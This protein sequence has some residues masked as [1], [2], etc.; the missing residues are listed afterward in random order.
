MPIDPVELTR[1]LVRCP[2]VTPAE[3]GALDTLEEA[4][5]TLGIAATRLTFGEDKPVQ[6]LFATTGGEG[7]GAKGRHLA[8]N[9]HV[10][11][12]PPGDADAWR[13]DPFSATLED[14]LIFGRGSADMKSGVACFIAALARILEEDGGIDG[15]VSLMI[16]GD[17]EAEAVYGTKPLVAWADA[18][19]HRFDGCLVGEPTSIERLG[20]NAKIGRRG[21]ATAELHVFG[22]QGHTAYGH[23]AHNAAA[24]MVR[25]LGALT[26][27]P[28]DAGTDHFQPTSLE[29][30]TIDVGNPASNVIPGKAFA[31]FNMRYNDGQS[32]ASLD[33]WIRE[34]LDAS[35]ES[36]ELSIGSTGDAFL[37]SEGPLSNAVRASVLAVTGIEPRFSTDGGTS[38]AR[39]IKD[40][41]PVVEFGLT[42]SSMHG[43]DE[44]VRVDEIEALT[45]IYADFIRRFL[46]G[47]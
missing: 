47:E 12:V 2:S 30:T 26:A 46:A 23:R 39:F 36:Y 29:I 32:V 35:G 11:V 14:G 43:I 7:T 44:H 21:S 8:F 40:Y 9:G 5:S 13:H 22:K 10:D 42:G 25:V 20:D 24:A 41:C 33:H 4:L 17:E 3:A 27:E 45:R 31:R 34:R 6:N 28:V 18:Q 38:D 37:T 19:G 1:A 16:T 15:R